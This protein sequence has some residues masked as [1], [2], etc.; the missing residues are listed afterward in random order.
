MKALI[1]CAAL[2]AAGCG[3]AGA[4]AE[5]P[6]LTPDGWGPLRIGMTRAEVEEAVGPPDADGG[7]LEPETCDE[8]RPARAPAGL[9][10]MILEG[11]L[12]R[13]SVREPTVAT[14]RGIAPGAPAE[15]VRRAYGDA[16]SVSPHRYLAPEGEYLTAW[17]DGRRVAASEYVEDPAA[18]GIRYEIDTDGLVEAIHGGG[19]SIQLVEGCA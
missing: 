18:R 6:V 10:V 14:E 5:D 16:L 2:L 8:Y 19:P 4:A 12:A 15:A 3:G 1:L 13:I 7:W 9:Y 17:N 11:R